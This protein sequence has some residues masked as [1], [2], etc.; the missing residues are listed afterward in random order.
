MFADAF[1][2]NGEDDEAS[3]SELI[4]GESSEPRPTNDTDELSASASA[5]MDALFNPSS[6]DTVPAAEPELPQEEVVGLSIVP[7]Y[8]KRCLKCTALTEFGEKL[9]SSCHFSKGNTL[10]PAASI[11]ITQALPLDRMAQQYVEAERNQNFTLVAQYA[12][13][14]ATFSET[15]RNVLTKRIAYFRENL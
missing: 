2:S 7:V 10:C 15:N 14:M 4:S 1:A 13:R 9:W 6:N 11:R 3:I 12:A 8:R 5:A